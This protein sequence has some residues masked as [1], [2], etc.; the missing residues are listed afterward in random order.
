MED[1]LATARDECAS[2]AWLDVPAVLMAERNMAEGRADA[3]AEPIGGWMG[4]AANWR[5]L[6]DEKK[7]G[8]GAMAAV[9]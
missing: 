4:T 3:A 9:M 7:D 6:R 2:T 8:G 5:A 1:R